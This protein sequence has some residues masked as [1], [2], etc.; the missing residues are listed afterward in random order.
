MQ[1]EQYNGHGICPIAR[2]N[3]LGDWMLTVLIEI[4]S[5]VDTAMR[6][7]VSEHSFPTEAEA[8]V[9]GFTAGKQRIDAGEILDSADGA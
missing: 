1:I 9:F 8:L 5:G 2:Q 7:F 6:A 3:A 4:G